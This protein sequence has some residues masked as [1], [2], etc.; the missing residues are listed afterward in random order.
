MQPLYRGLRTSREPIEPSTATSAKDRRTASRL[1]SLPELLAC[2]ACLARQLYYNV[3]I[4]YGFAGSHLAWRP[5]ILW[6][7]A[8]K[9]T[10]DRASKGSSVTALEGL[11]LVLW[12]HKGH[13]FVRWLDF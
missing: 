5:Q 7:M 9:S 13:L 6:T 12:C 10:A 4:Y 2:F 3:C 8:A 11:L 1:P